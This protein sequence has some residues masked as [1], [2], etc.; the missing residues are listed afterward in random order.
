[1]AA[2]RT[3][4]VVVASLAAGLVA[5]PAL[6]IGALAGA[7]EHVI[8]GAVLLAFAA[9]WGVLALLSIVL[10]SQPQ[11]WAILPASFMGLWGAG[12]LV[13]AVSRRAR[14]GQDAVFS[15]ANKV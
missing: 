12:L 9:S 4:Y 7:E 13:F 15:P 8:T 5:A 1:M 6:V 11:R 2:S 3:G 14:S 10:T